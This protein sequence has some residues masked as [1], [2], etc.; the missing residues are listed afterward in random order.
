MPPFGEADLLDDPIELFGRWYELA[1]ERVPLADAITLATID[2]DGLP[3]ARMVLLKGFGPEGFRFFTNKRSVKGD[4]LAAAPAAALVVFWREL[5]R[6]VRIRGPVEQ[7]DEAASDAYFATRPR[8][9]QIGAAASPQS[10]SLADRAELDRLVKEVEERHRGAEEVPR[11]AHWGGYRVVPHEIE[12]WQGQV[13]RLHDRFRYSRSG[14][15]G[16]SAQRL[17][18]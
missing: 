8:E 2:P 5:D 3:D 15:D 18:P 16:W 12:F 6:Q 7:V 1:S 9:S 14:S 11:P 4:Q 10:S 13:G 17:A